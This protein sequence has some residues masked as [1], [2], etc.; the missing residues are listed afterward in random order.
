MNAKFTNRYRKLAVATALALFCQLAVLLGAAVN[1]LL[2][3]SG[4]ANYLLATVGSFAA[5]ACT[6]LVPLYLLSS[7]VAAA[8]HWQ[9]RHAET[10][11]I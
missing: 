9:Q 4:S 6:F 10:R 7:V 8:S 2:G 11:P 3:D 1:L 5:V